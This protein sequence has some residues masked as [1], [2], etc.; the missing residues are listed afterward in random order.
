[1]TNRQYNWRLI[2]V[3]IALVGMVGVVLSLI[4]FTNNSIHKPLLFGGMVMAAWG[5]VLAIW[6]DLDHNNK[7]RK[8]QRIMK[9][10]EYEM[11]WQTL[12]TVLEYSDPKET[13][14][15]ELIKRIESQFGIGKP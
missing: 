14:I 8:E 4:I 1:M 9:T 2:G 3:A 15:L 12:K 13:K 11:A 7:V 6:N 10:N 5:F